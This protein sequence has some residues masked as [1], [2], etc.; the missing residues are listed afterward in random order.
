MRVGGEEEEEHWLSWHLREL[1]SAFSCFMII[2][3]YEIMLELIKSELKSSNFDTPDHKLLKW[4]L[5]KF[6]LALDIHFYL[7]HFSLTLAITNLF[8]FLHTF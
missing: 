6:L 8:D 5:R 7:K 4:L 1:I 2:D 3:Q